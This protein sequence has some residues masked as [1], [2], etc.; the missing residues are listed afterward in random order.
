MI[1]LRAI[2]YCLTGDTGEEKLFMP[3]GPAASG[4]STFLEAVKA[5]MGDYAATADFESFLAKAANG[6]PR[7]D[8]RDW[9]ANGLCCPSRLTKA[10]AL[11]PGWSRC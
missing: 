9:P 7:N 2:G 10:A 8:I 5:T 4:K 6:G 3:I 1:F 11:R